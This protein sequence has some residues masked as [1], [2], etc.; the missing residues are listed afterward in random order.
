MTRVQVFRGCVLLSVLMYGLAPAVSG[1][2]QNSKRGFEIHEWGVL[3]GCQTDNKYFDTSRPLKMLAVR[4]PIIYVH[5]QDKKPFSL[6]V[7]FMDG[8]PTDTYPVAELSSNSVSWTNVRFSRPEQ[9]AIRGSRTEEFVPLKD[10]MP[11]LNDVDADELTYGNQ[12]A[13]FLFY[14]GE[15]RYD[16][17]I[18]VKHD[19]TDKTATVQNSG[20]NTV[21]DVIVVAP[22]KGE[23][24]FSIDVYVG[25]VQ[26]LKAGE[27]ISV[28]LLPSGN[29][30]TFVPQL[31]ALGFTEKEAV[32]FD[33][34][35]KELNFD[36]KPEKTVR[37]LYILVRSFEQR[38][39]DKRAQETPN[40]TSEPSIA[41]APQVQR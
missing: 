41:S 17:K 40:K 35:W 12:T 28:S 18:A 23:G 25:R 26:E 15:T 10:I 1:E 27:K 19:L 31:I 34:L 22:Q 16:N 39:T 33:K 8:K 24:P 21:Y 32:S 4:E 3:A 11:V 37:A 5:S 2:D 7:T 20:S 9:K 13:R 29:D 30:V 38:P 36:P 6:R 14:E